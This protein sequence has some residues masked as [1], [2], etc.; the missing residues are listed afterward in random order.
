MSKIRLFGRVMSQRIIPAGS[1]E[2]IAAYPLPSGGQLNNVHMN[3]HVVGAEG[4][5]YLQAVMYG[6]S[7]FVVPIMD[8]DVS[9]N[10]Q[11]VWDQ[12]IPKDADQSAGSFDLDTIA[13][14]TTPEFEM[15]EADWN[16]VFDLTA[17]APK[18][19]YRRRR[20]LSVV[21]GAVAYEPVAAAADTWTPGEH[22]TGKVG[23][24]VRV[25]TP[26]AVMFG[27][28][29]P[30]LDET[31][32]TE[33][34]IPLEQEWFMLQYLDQTLQNAFMSI[35]GMTE[36]GAESP[37]EES[38]AFLAKLIEDDVFEEVAGSFAAQSWTVF[39][40]MTFDITVPGMPEF[41]QLSSEG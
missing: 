29:S 6:L 1:D 24:K 19:I 2:V 17:M 4:F 16:G 30:S 31:T 21:D 7:G 8:P 36:A 11:N 25:N 34:L 28:S 3:V 20:L 10:Y 23:R 39:T 13:V 35:V 38:A 5:P 27:F 40:Q 37:Y 18:E 33:P 12:L 41:K 14:D 9:I 32:T 22:I 26:S 15:G